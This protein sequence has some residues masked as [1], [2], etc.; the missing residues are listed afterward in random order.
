[1]YTLRGHESIAWTDI[2]AVEGVQITPPRWFVRLNFLAVF[3]GGS[4]AARL[5]QAGRALM[6]AGARVN[7]LRLTGRDGSVRHIWVSDQMGGKAMAN[8]DRLM[9]AVTRAGVS[10]PKEVVHLKALFPPA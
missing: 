5:G 1:M 8:V 4:A 2:R 3:L 6:I 10:Q 9:E 7:G